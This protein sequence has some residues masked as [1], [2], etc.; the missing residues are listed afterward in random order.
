LLGDGVEAEHLNDDALGRALD[1]VHTY[2]P[3]ML[4]G[5]LAA[6][7]VKRLGLSCQIG[8][9]DST[10]FHVDGIFNSDQ[11]APERVIYITQGY[12]RHHR[13]DLNQVTLQLISEHQAGIPL[14]MDALRGYSS[15]KNSF[16]QTLNA[17]L[18]QLPNGV[19]LSLIVAD[20]A[21][22]TAKTFQDLGDFPW[23][24]RITETIGGTQELIRAASNEWMQTRPERAYTAL[25]A[26]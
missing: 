2:G 24:S 3:E 5:Q 10:R 20:S 18:D 22:Y 6:Q 26:S 4:Y 7:T 21:L 11:E 23:I 17:H 25:C 15:D 16:R 14:W 1:A 8:H 12:S 19:G 9:I 13:P